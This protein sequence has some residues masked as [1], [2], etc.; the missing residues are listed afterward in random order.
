M[1]VKG[2]AEQW[3]GGAEAGRGEE[4]RPGEGAGAG[5]ERGGIEAMTELTENTDPFIL[6]WSV[7][8]VSLACVCHSDFILTAN[9]CRFPHVSLEGSSGQKISISR[10]LSSVV[11]IDR[12][13]PNCSF[14]KQS[15]L[16]VKAQQHLTVS[17]P[18]VIFF[19][20]NWFFNISSCVSY[21]YH[22]TKCLDTVVDTEC[23]FIILDEFV[24]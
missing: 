11:K 13:I 5:A 10:Q 14:S 23:F 8:L 18:Q 19:F 21:S 16:I 22:I 9:L 15:S 2:R 7:G 20:F 4:K 12:S 17:W 24:Y 6:L 3:K 1:Q